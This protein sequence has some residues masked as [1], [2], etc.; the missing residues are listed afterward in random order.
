MKTIWNIICVF[1]FKKRKLRN[2][3]KDVLCITSTP[4]LS[5]DNFKRISSVS[6]VTLELILSNE[7]I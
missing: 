7:L 6:S 1:I 3:K 2:L 4:N 5:L